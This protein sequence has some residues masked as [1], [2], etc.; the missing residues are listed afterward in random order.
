MRSARAVRSEAHPA[1]KSI[2][3]LGMVL[4]IISE[5]F[6]FGSLF[7]T[8]YYLRGH[9]P[10]W[11][12]AGV[13]LDT[14]LMV[15]NT[16]VL[17]ASSATTQWA[18]SAAHRGN[19]GAVSTGLLVSIALGAI[20]LVFKFW[21]WYTVPFRPWEHAYGSIF[22]TLTGFHALH[23]LGGILLLGALWLRFRRRPVSPLHVEIG[24]LYWHYVDAIWLVVFTTIFIVR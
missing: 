8:Y 7:L 17:L 10:V 16:L 24:G 9:T 21:D 5:A 4:F 11:P 13:E 2:F 6:L 22:Y 12:P 1:D 14:P 18:V 15:L 23:L 20:F 19:A 3:Y